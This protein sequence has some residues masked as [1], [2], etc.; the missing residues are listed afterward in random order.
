MEL[1]V[2]AVFGIYLGYKFNKSLQ[3][4]AEKHPRFEPVFLYGV[5]TVALAVFLGWLGVIVA[6]TLPVACMVYPK[7][8]GWYKKFFDKPQVAELEQEDTEESG[9][10]NLAA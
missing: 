3:G 2:V 10:S 1:L 6:F 7:L 4:I 9:S 8:P 5:F